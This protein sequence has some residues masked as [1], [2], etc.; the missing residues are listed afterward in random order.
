MLVSRHSLALALA[1]WSVVVPTSLLSCAGTDPDGSPNF[2]PLTPFAGGSGN[3]PQS[4]AGAGLGP[5]GGANG[6]GTGGSNAQGNGGNSNV[7]QGGNNTAGNPNNGNAGSVSNSGA[8]GAGGGNAGGGVGRVGAEACPPGPFS[9][10]LPANVN[11]GVQKLVSVG[12]NDFFNWEGLVWTDGA[13]Y[14]SEIGNGNVSQISRYT[15]GSGLQRGVLN[16]TGSNGMGLDQNGDLLLADHKVGAISVVALPGLTLDAGAQQRNATRFNSPNDLVLRGD[17][18]LYFTDPDFQAPQPRP[19]DGTRVYRIAPPFLTGEITIVDQS[20]N[21]P[22]GVTLSPDGNTLYVAGGSTLR[23]YALDAAG[24]A[25]Q[26]DDIT[27]DMQVADGMTV[28]CAGNVYAVENSGRRVRVFNPDGEEIGAIGPGPFDDMGLTNVAFGGP[29]RT[30]LFISS[31]SQD[32]RGG[33]Y[34][35]ELQVPGLPY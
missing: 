13:L 20:I 34:S 4:S 28:D 21:N 12:A 16:D 18:N 6:L 31:A 9:A 30:T 15:P 3:N 7:G 10:P 17:G 26:P 1:A 29:N 33:L 5:A 27:N 11:A 23:R 32:Q 8:G 25:T 2:N 24:V 14:F 22:N 35:V 19:Q